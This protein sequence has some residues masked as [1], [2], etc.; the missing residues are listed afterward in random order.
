MENYTSWNMAPAGSIRIK[1]RAY[2][3]SISANSFKQIKSKN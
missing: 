3:G 2:P 1:M